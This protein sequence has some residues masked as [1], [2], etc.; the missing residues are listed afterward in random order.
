MTSCRLLAVSRPSAPRTR[1]RSGGEPHSLRRLP[2]RGSCPSSTVR[3]PSNRR[4]VPRVPHHG[5]DPR[6][7]TIRGPRTASPCAIGARPSE[8][9]FVEVHPTLAASTFHSSPEGGFC[10]RFYTG[11][12]LLDARGAARPGHPAQRPCSGTVPM[13]E[14]TSSP[15]PRSTATSAHFPKRKIFAARLGAPTAFERAA[16]D[17]ASGRER[18]SSIG[19]L[20]A[21]GR[22]RQILGRPGR[23]HRRRLDEQHPPRL[24]R[25]CSL[26]VPRRAIPS[27]RVPTVYITY[28]LFCLRAQPTSTCPRRAGHQPSTPK[29][30]HFGLAD[31]RNSSPRTVSCSLA[32]GDP[33]QPADP[34]LLF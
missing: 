13:G 25:C 2:Q 9:A 24:H 16:D 30:G 5:T 27:P 33:P 1:G 21:A 29:C 23:T 3:P 17:E 4:R 34:M 31:V 26:G 18:R 19:T 6:S 11:G 20:W 32:T 8:A 7:T 14:A 22:A 10:R 12:Q 15:S 28:S